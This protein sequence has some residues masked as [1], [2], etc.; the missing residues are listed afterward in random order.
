[1]NY[2]V[3]SNHRSIHGL[4]PF[5]RNTAALGSGVVPDSMPVSPLV[6]A[7]AIEKLNRSDA[8]TRVS[9]E[10]EPVLVIFDLLAARVDRI[11]VGVDGPIE[12]PPG[13]VGFCI[14]RR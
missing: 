4:V 14:I 10:D 11:I 3:V 2:I 9:V 8:G 13:V 1:M 7:D 5:C 6:G 12:V